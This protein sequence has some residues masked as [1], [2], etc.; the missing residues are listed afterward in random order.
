MNKEICILLTNQ[1]GQN[2]LLSKDN[3][4][5]ASSINFNIMTNDLV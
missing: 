1:L 3:Y 5:D 4:F 2:M